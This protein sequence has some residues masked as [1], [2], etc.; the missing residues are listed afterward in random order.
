ML[1]YRVVLTPAGYVFEI[2]LCFT[3]NVSIKPQLN[4]EPYVD[5]VNTVCECL[6]KYPSVVWIIEDD[7]RKCPKLCLGLQLFNASKSVIFQID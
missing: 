6:I 3:S 1:L 2:V 5:N 7:F 4:L